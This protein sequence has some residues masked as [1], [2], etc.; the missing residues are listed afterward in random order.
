MSRPVQSIDKHVVA[1]HAFPFINP[2]VNISADAIFSDLLTL[3]RQYGDDSGFLKAAKV[4]INP[5]ITVPTAWIHSDA[6]VEQMSFSADQDGVAFLGIDHSIMSMHICNQKTF[7]I[8]LQKKHL[9]SSKYKVKGKE[10]KYHK[11]SNFFTYAINDSSSPEN[12]HIGIYFPN[13]MG[14]DE[15]IAGA[16]KNAIVLALRHAAGTK[17]LTTDINKEVVFICKL[18]NNQTSL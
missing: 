15:R 17:F 16:L 5:Y 4:L 1:F 18:A 12:P 7:R 9:I 10:G 14:G 13:V 11:L 3:R 6:S 8:N 2:Q